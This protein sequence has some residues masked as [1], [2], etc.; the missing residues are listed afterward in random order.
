MNKR[1][2]FISVEGI[3]GAGKST[4]IAFI[5]EYLK[6][7]GYPVTLTREPGGT[8]LG[9]KIRGLLLNSTNMHKITELLL[10][11]A[12]RQELIHNVIMPNLDNGVCVIADRFIDASIAYQGIGRGLGIDTVEK[13]ISILEPQITTDLTILFDTPLPIALHRVS[14]SRNKDRIENEADNFFSAVQKAY[15]DIVKLA[16]HRVKLISTDQPK[17][18]T[19]K[20]IATLLANLVSSTRGG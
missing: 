12:S 7:L 2:L 18:D 17:E 4:H 1:G 19:Q 8:D 20:M 6:N 9:E 10:M 13:V 16:P 14:R 15:H 11:F 5:S 3:D